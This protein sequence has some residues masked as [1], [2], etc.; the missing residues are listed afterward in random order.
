MSSPRR[1]LI[2]CDKFKGSLSA[3]E[4]NE[5][6]ARGFGKRFPGAVI[7]VRAI[8]DGGEGFVSTAARE[9]NGEWI[10]TEVHDAAGRP[11]KARYLVASHQGERVAVMEMAEASGLWRIPAGERDILR[12]STFG[13]G[14]MI[15][16]AFES[17]QV[18]RL[19]I[20][21]GGSATNDGGAG[22]AAALGVR[23]LDADGNEIRPLPLD[24]SEQLAAVDESMFLR[25]PPVIAACDVTNPLLGVN[26]A[27]RVFGPQK[28]ADETSMPVLESA[29]E[30]LVSASAGW[31]EA[32]KPGAGAAGGLGFGLMCFCGAEL[33]SGFGL[34]AELTGLMAEVERAD[35]VVTGEGSLDAQSL[36]GKGPFSLAGMARV[37][38][39][40]VIAFCGTAD[41][42]ARAAGCFDEII[43]LK[44]T[45]LPKD[46]LMS[47]AAELLESLAADRDLP[48]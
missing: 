13:T 39:K 29:L 11:V 37:H 28:G 20:G 27:T 31:R 12:A 5:A 46:G 45:G 15:R 36:S 9:L 19:I 14:E 21:L 16:H 33:R 23:F 47:R 30:R 6:I 18:D 40:R 48:P 38:G 2:A 32:E 22:M 44:S 35:L 25:M 26:G 41:D 43:E 10:E 4:A 7:E 8:A 3:D 24:L 1:I 17:R 42:A 34:I